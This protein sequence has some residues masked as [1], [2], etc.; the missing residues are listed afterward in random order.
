[1][2]FG[3]DMMRKPPMYCQG[4]QD[5]H[6]KVRWYF[7]RPGF[8]RVPLPGLPWSPQFMAA[9][10]AA[11]GGKVPVAVERSKP[12]TVSALVAAYYRSSEYLNLRP[13]TQRTYRSTIEPFREAHGEKSVANLKREHIKAILA[14][15]ADRPAVANNWRK[16]IK[17]LMHFAIQEMGLRN[18]D[19]TA[20][21]RKLKTGSTGYRTWTEEEIER[22]NVRHPL[23]TK[24]RLAL[25]LLLYTG[26]RR[27]DVV[28]MGW[29]NVREGVLITRQSKTGTQVEIPL[30]PTLLASI[31]AFPQRNMTFLLTDYGRPFAVAGFGNWFRDRVVEAGLPNGLSAH[32]LRKAACRRL[33]EAGC[34]GPQIMSIS[35]HRNLKEVQTYID[36]AD[37]LGMAR[38]AIQKQITAHENRTKIVKPL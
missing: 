24:P 31:E 15:M 38:E 36:A 5:R 17:I 37:R 29:Q 11:M 10:E 28:R 6:G 16:T 2:G 26:Q 3:A 30:H 32:G 1:M 23:G 33:A 4:F 27:A 22:F 20:G 9:H 25:D 21:I 12:G 19:P 7:R 8:K 18:D 34:T 13:I 14:K 35:G